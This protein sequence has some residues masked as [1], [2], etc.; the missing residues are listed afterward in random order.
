[1]KRLEVRLRLAP[2]QERVVGQ[3]AETRRRSAGAKVVFE[4]DP[5]FLREPLWLSPFKLPPRPGLVEHRDFDFGPIFGL[6]DDSLPDGWGLLLMDRAFK[7][8]GKILAE[9]SVLDRLAYLG[10]RTMGA[11]TYHP[12][13][14]TE[15]SVAQPLDLAEMASESREVFSGRAGEVLGRLLRAGGSPGG[16]RPKVLVGVSGDTLLS[17]EE[18]LPPGFSHWIVKF[19]SREEPLEGGAVEWAYSAMARRAG[20]ELPSTR[21]FETREGERFFGVERFDRRGN[22]RFHVHTFGNLI[23]SNFRIPSCDYRQ[24]L[25]V[26]RL[27]TRDRRDVLEAFRRMA[28]NVFT[29]NRDDHV[30]NFAFRLTPEDGWR[31]APAYDLI[32]SHGPGGEHSMTVAGEGRAP[33][34]KHLLSLA[35]P[36]GIEAAEAEAICEEV[37]EACNQ[38][39]EVA[40][41]AGV[42][43]STARFVEGSIAENLARR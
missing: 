42:E 10:T 5:V 37:A 32:W 38:W 24:L 12:P 41:E 21:L 3:L 19:G 40:R 26:T 4:Y 8:Q 29:H 13:A 6:F 16:A 35:S 30:K 27:L 9:I 20:I 34:G 31:L 33:T 14:D 11:L 22:E 2:G 25:E 28:F 23:H 15:N 1:M 43:A 17:G 18:D 39:R 36:V 7:Q